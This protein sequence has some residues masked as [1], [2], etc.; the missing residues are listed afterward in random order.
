MREGQHDG[1]LLDGEPCR[2]GGD[3]SLHLGRGFRVG[4]LGGHLR[5]NDDVLEQGRQQVGE[6][7]PDEQVERGVVGDD[8]GHGSAGAEEAVEGGPIGV[9]VGQRVL[10]RRSVTAEP[11][12]G[13]PAVVEAE[14]SLHLEAAQR[15]FRAAVECDVLHGRA[16]NVV[17]V[18]GLKP[19]GD[20]VG[21]VEG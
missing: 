11:V 13:I 7:E 5:W 1:G 4:H 16:G 6:P 21:D 10:N 18:G 8:E 19:G 9:E 2:L 3:E 20:V 17:T 15:A 12:L 14:Q